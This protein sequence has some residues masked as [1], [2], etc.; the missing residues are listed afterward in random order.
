MEDHHSMR[1]WGRR[2][3]LQ[4]FA[5]ALV[6]T[7]VLMLIFNYE[8]ELSIPISFSEDARFVR[9]EQAQVP[10]SSLSLPFTP[11]V[12][13]GSGSYKLDKPTGKVAG[14]ES[15]SQTGQDKVVDDLLNGRKDGFFI[16]IGG[17]DGELHSNSLFFEKNRNWSGLLVE[18]NPYTYKQ[19]VARDRKCGM[20][21]ACISRDVESMD[22][23]IGGGLTTAVQAASESHL[24]RIDKD[25]KTY[26]KGSQ[27][28]GY[29]EVVKTRC[30]T[31]DVLLD[32]MSVQHVDYFS[33]DVEGAE[34]FVLESFDW[35]RMDVDVFTIEI[36]EHREEINAL[37]RKHGY[38]RL[39][40]PRLNFD[41]VFV[42]DEQAQVPSEV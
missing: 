8:T 4:T 1:Q 11:E 13:Y 31:F 5:A 20:V 33:L 30:T 35:A 29:G 7:I 21:H 39:E 18:A 6:L 23:K 27:W 41:D 36:Q 37:M 14:T 19:M 3:T 10:S 9:D 34:M 25:A 42:R 16:E 22:F 15:W 2:S 40:P 32:M 12:V 24:A 38:H 26:G 17:Y 28:S